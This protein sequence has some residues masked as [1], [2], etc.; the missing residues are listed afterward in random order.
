MRPYR[1]PVA[2]ENNNLVADLTGRLSRFS[3]PW[4]AGG[5]G[6]ATDKIAALEAAGVRVTTSPAQMGTTM[7]ALMRD[8]GLL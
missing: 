8:R 3:R 6:T 5:K 4:P 2:A 1:L 7:T